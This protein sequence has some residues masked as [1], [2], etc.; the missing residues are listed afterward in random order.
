MQIIDDRGEPISSKSGTRGLMLFFWKKPVEPF[1]KEK[2]KSRI[3]STSSRYQY[4]YDLPVFRGGCMQRCAVIGVLCLGLK[5]A[6]GPKSKKSLLEDRKQALN[7]GIETIEDVIKGEIF[8]T[9][10]RR[11]AKQYVQKLVGAKT[12][13][14]RKTT[15]KKFFW[16]G[17][18]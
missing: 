5:L 15:P 7:T 11:R 3:C 14:K 4:G 2:K 10:L 17:C 8:K 9:L 13:L 16:K 1:E 12:E 6:V 18:C